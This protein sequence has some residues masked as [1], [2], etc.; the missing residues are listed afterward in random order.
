M[1][2]FTKMGLSSV[3]CATILLTGCGGGGGD[4]STPST[5]LASTTASDPYISNAR[6]YVDSTPNGKYDAGELQSSLTNI[7][8]KMTWSS[9]I[10]LGSTIRMNAKYRGTHNGNEYTG[11]LLAT[12]VSSS[13]MITPLT[14]LTYK[15]LT[16]TQIKTMLIACGLTD[17]PEDFD[18]NADPMSIASSTTLDS[19][20]SLA[21][22]RATI[23][24]SGMLK[25]MEGSTTLKVMTG[26][27]IYND[28][29]NN[30]TVKTI[31]TNMITGVKNGL[32]TTLLASLKTASDNLYGGGLPRIP[33]EVVINTAVTIMDK[34]V[35][36]GYNACNAGG[37]A[38]AIGG[39]IQGQMGAISSSIST[40]GPYY[41]GIYLQRSNY[42][43]TAGQRTGISNVNA[44]MLLGYDT[45]G[46]LNL[47]SD[48][49]IMVQTSTP[50]TLIS[51]WN[52]TTI[53][54]Y[55]SALAI[56]LNN[57]RG[58]AYDKKR[59][60]IYIAHDGNITGGVISK[61]SPDGNV[62]DF[63]SVGKWITGLYK[64]TSLAVLDNNLYV[65]D[66][67]TTRVFALD[68]MSMTG[69]NSATNTNIVS[70]F[71]N[72]DNNH[73]KDIVVDRGGNIYLSVE[74]Q[75]KLYKFTYSYSSDT[76]RAYED[77]KYQLPNFLSLFNLENS[78]DGNLILGG[79]SP[80]LSKVSETGSTSIINNASNNTNGT[81]I[82]SVTLY[83]K[84]TNGKGIYFVVDSN[85]TIRT[86][87]EVNGSITLPMTNGD[88]GVNQ[89]GDMTYIKIKNLLVVPTESNNT[90]R[91]YKVQ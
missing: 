63:K 5:D 1:K 53:T 73:L 25:I 89:A 10:P 70:N 3:V 91:A 88:M 41:Y 16:S 14:V 50:T 67:N 30:G 20:S 65:A 56:D 54:G 66:Y 47:Q 68:D 81:V 19:N 49:T 48:G 32:N 82:N 62:T 83:N 79:D 51:D 59:D 45:T 29:E 9:A 44:N 24:I 72:P 35:E 22:I 36:A 12:K 23:A 13:G 69:N 40:L 42:T 39:A 37:N 2:I 11:P 46:S 18:I 7:N 75:N 87:Y 4:S 27:Q 71:V 43:L 61:L 38:A 15:G 60:V 58:V 90:I 80:Y 85:R 76:Y 8:G 64:P 26:A 74:E 84:D 77:I 52:T 17:L 28:I 86:V 33:T 55:T 6:F 21:M 31:F 57:T 78:T 34:M